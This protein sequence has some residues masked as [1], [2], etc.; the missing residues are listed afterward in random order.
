MK[1]L[2]MTPEAADELKAKH[3]YYNSMSDTA[4]G[5][6]KGYGILEGLR[7]SRSAMTAIDIPDGCKLAVVDTKKGVD[8][9]TEGESYVLLVQEVM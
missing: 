5:R 8:F 4:Q 2:V 6:L 7:F 3:E 9:N 1:I